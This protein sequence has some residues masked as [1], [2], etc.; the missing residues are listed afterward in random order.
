MTEP[1]RGAINRFVYSLQGQKEDDANGLS[2]YIATGRNR[3]SC[4][5]P[6]QRWIHGENDKNLQRSKPQQHP[7][8]KQP[9]NVGGYLHTVY[10]NFIQFLCFPIH[11]YITWLPLKSSFCF[12]GIICVIFSMWQLDHFCG[13]FLSMW[14]KDSEVSYYQKRGHTDGS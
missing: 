9:L 11:G 1:V 13:L 12:L 10:C 7:P 14:H 5:K 3:T 8:S 2:L 6:V 4:L